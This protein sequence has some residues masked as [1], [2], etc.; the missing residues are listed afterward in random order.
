MTHEPIVTEEIKAMIAETQAKQPAITRGVIEF[1]LHDYPDRVRE[2]VDACKAANLLPGEI[3]AAYIAAIALNI[4]CFTTPTPGAK[5][6]I[7]KAIGD[8]LEVELLR[9]L[10]D[11][12]S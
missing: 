2:I 12:K 7:C 3:L 11:V 9:T 6:L 4:S 5:E 8:L 10:E 1:A